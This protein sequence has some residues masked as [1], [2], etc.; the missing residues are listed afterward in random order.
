MTSARVVP[1]PAKPAR[2]T[3]GGL[4]R[5][6]GGV[7]GRQTHW[8][9]AP[10]APRFAA[11]APPAAAWRPHDPPNVT[12]SPPGPTQDAVL[13]R[14]HAAPSLGA[15]I[16]APRPVRMSTATPRDARVLSER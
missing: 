14:S 1:R 4:P 12:P 3:L 15:D 9:G 6:W 7:S 11:P 13:G 5:Y 2:Q 10:G 8:A 16:H